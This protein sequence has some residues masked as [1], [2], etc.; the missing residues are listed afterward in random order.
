MLNTI[1]NVWKWI[2][3]FF[4]R[5]SSSNADS[6]SNSIDLQRHN[7]VNLI[8]Q[9]IN[10]DRQWQYIIYAQEWLFELWSWWWKERIIWHMLTTN[11]LNLLTSLSIWTLKVGRPAVTTTV[12]VTYSF[13]LLWSFHWPSTCHRPCRKRQD[14]TRQHKTKQTKYGTIRPV[15]ICHSNKNPTVKPARSMVTI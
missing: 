4:L 2:F 15:T 3:F 9:D 10:T 11:L 12:T 1:S 5:P 14:N 6:N 7:S 8:K 13:T